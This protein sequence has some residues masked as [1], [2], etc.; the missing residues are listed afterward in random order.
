MLL[1]LRIAAFLVGAYVS[2]Q[3]TAEVW[4]VGSVFG[5]VVLFWQFTLNQKVHLASYLGFLLASTLIYA[6]ILKMPDWGVP[7]TGFYRLIV[8]EM[9]VGTFLLPLA[10]RLFLKTAWRRVFVTIPAVYVLSYASA[11][12]LDQLNPTPPLNYFLN[13]VAVWQGSYLLF[14]FAPLKGLE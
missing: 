2:F 3:Y 9:L 1:V 4:V 14:M 10:Q 12:L 8:P 7:E 5:A 11:L 13:V 6:L